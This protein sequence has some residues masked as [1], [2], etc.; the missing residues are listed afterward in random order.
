MT[1]ASGVKEP[2]LVKSEEHFF[3]KTFHNTV[4]NQIQSILC[5]FE[6]SHSF[7]KFQK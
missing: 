3:K 1:K 7:I 5:N 4:A 6:G 2:L